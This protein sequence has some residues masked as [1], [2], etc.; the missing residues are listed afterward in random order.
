MSHTNLQMMTQ[1]YSTIARIV[2]LAWTER[3][4][5]MRP[6]DADALLDKLKIRDLP[7]RLTWEI[8]NAPVI[9]AVPVVR[10]FYCKHW[11]EPRSAKTIPWCNHLK[12]VMHASDFCNYGQRREDGDA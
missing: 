2:A 4:N 7:I 3:R 5:T 6:I 8:Q 10:C 9:D 12:T 1:M 11:Q